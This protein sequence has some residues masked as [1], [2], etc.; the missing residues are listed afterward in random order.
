MVPPL[1][2]Q[3]VI[4]PQIQHRR[5]QLWHRCRS[6]ELHEPPDRI[7]GRHQRTLEQHRAC[8]CHLTFRRAGRQVQHPQILAIRLLR[9]RHLQL[10][11]GLAEDQG[12]EEFLAVAVR[13]KRAGLAQ[14]RQMTCR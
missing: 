5:R 6:W 14:E 4:R 3:R 12:R 11:I 9:H 2:D 13:R 10:V 1:T 8:D 7:E